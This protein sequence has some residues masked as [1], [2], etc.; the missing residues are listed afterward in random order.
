MAAARAQASSPT[1]FIEQRAIFGDLA[2]STAFV[3]DY[4]HALATIH[5]KGVRA[6]LRDLHADRA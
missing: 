3:E 1:A 6:A 5:T 2:E 4:T